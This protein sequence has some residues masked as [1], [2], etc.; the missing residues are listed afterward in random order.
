MNLSTQRLPISV[1]RAIGRSAFSGLFVASLL[2]GGAIRANAEDTN[3]I[4]D[5]KT[6]LQKV[7]EQLPRETMTLQGYFSVRRR[8]GIEAQRLR[9][10]MTLQW[11]QTPSMATYL[12]RDNFGKNLEKLTVLR[13]T[14][15]LPHY[16]YGKG[17]ELK[18]EKVP[19]LSQPIQ[20]SD[21]SWLDLSMGFLWWKDGI[22]TGTEEI[23][24]RPCYCLELPAPENAGTNG[25]PTHSVSL[26]L[27]QSP[28]STV[29]LWIDR[30]A[31]ILMKAEG[32]DSDQKLIRKLWIK[33]FKKID[34]QWMIKDM[35]VES[36]PVIHQTKIRVEEIGCKKPL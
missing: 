18:T 23:K 36:Y 27:S 20:E 24:G 14:K 9:F 26:P 22:V 35:L 28:Y 5:A 6:V 15:G 30:K 16:T 32:R 21:I 3:N 1:C 12:I 19:P 11:G 25:S 33:S 34:G 8:R 4:P 29:R 17:E 13:D 7:R 10:E 31:F 2:L